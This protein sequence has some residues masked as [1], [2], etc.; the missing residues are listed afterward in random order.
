MHKSKYSFTKIGKS[1]IQNI[2]SCSPDHPTQ[3][4]HIGLVIGGDGL[5]MA[6]HLL[7][8]L[9]SPADTV[10]VSRTFPV[11][12]NDYCVMLGKEAIDAH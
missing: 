4:P 9:Q 8:L 11:L 1:T 12:V 10:G 2:Y 6:P 7:L 5:V 3:H